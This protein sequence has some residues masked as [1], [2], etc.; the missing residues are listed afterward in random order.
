MLILSTPL[1]TVVTNSKTN[2]IYDPS[3]FQSIER[4]SFA[5]IL[6]DLR[7]KLTKATFNH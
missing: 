5:P 7:D 3:T 1:Q 6:F 2:G 4:Y